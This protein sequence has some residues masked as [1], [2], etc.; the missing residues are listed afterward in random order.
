MNSASSHPVKDFASEDSL[1]ENVWEGKERS[2]GI[3]LE[4]GAGESSIAGPLNHKLVNS[5]YPKSIIKRDLSRFLN[6]RNPLHNAF[7]SNPSRN[8]NNYRGRPGQFYS[9]YLFVSLLEFS[10]S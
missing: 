8:T 5:E 2:G 9:F 3:G 1:E 6:S 10:L 4:K 7:S